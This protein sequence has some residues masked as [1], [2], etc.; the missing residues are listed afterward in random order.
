VKRITITLK[1]DT[2]DRL[3]K[4]SALTGIPQARLVELALRRL[5]A[6]Q[7]WAPS[8]GDGP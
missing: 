6:D 5:L 1:E 7:W 8:G 3:A 2:A 4:V